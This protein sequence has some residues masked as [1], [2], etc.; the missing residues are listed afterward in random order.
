MLSIQI[1]VPDGY[2]K[3]ANRQI[4][5]LAFEIFF[6]TSFDNFLHS[7]VYKLDPLKLKIIKEEKKKNIENGVSFNECITC[8]VNEVIDMIQDRLK[9]RARED[10]DCVLSD[11]YVSLGES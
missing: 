1:G 6:R 3:Y 10:F 5:L 8:F 4:G 11:F 7:G 2:A 9:D